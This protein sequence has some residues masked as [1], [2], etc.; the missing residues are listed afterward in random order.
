MTLRPDLVKRMLRRHC[1]FENGDPFTR[2][3]AGNFD[4]QLMSLGTL[5]FAG[6]DGSLVPLI[7]SWLQ[8]YPEA[9]EW[10]LGS[11]LYREVL[12]EIYVD[13]HGLFN[14][15]N[16]YPGQIRD[17]NY[18]IPPWRDAWI[19][20]AMS[21]EWKEA[22]LPFVQM[23][24]DQAINIITWFDAN[25]TGD[26]ITTDRGLD[27]AFDI[28]CQ[29]WAPNYY[30]LAETSYKDKLFAV[31]KAAESRIINP[32]WAQNS[33]ERKLGI[34]TGYF[35]PHNWTGQYDDSSMWQEE[36]EMANAYT[37]AP[38]LEEAREK[39]APEP[40]QQK[41]QTK[42][43]MELEAMRHLQER[44]ILPDDLEISVYRGLNVTWGD[45][46]V[47]FHRNNSYLYDQHLKYI[48]RDEA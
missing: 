40:E 12:N 6:V 39:P 31:I 10:N 9:A 28:A 11:Q 38:D 5:Q 23:Y 3:C 25:S 43:E 33:T 7:W 20:V 27:I 13:P 16:R 46:A 36:T 35:S 4:G 34:L 22:E 47:M 45:V 18:I 17:D 21:P 41:P 30:A 29:S 37:G 2:Q 48:R 24:I 26:R 8:K 1:T 19:R 15:I 32:R 42:M 14:R 44:G